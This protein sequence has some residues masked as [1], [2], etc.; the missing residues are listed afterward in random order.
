MTKVCNFKFISSSGKPSRPKEAMI[1]FETGFKRYPATAAAM[2]GMA[3]GYS[4]N[5]DNKKALKFMQ[6][7]LKAENNPQVKTTIDGLVKKLEN[8]EAIN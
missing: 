2:V 7:A 4:A 5:G 8:G 3:R 6:D 1:V